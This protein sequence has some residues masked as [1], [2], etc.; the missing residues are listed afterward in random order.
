MDALCMFV[1]YPEDAKVKTRLAKDI[2][3]KEAT[4][5]YKRLLRILIPEHENRSYKFYIAVTPEGKVRKFKKLYP[6]GT[7]IKQKGDNLGEIITH[8]LQRLHGEH[9][10]VIL[11]GSDC[12]D[13]THETITQA[14][15]ALD[16]N[17]VVIGPAMDGGYYLIG[18]NKYHNLFSE[19]DWSSEKVLDQ[20]LKLATDLKV[21]LL[22]EKRD[23]DTVDDA[24]HH[25]F[26]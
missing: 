25:H 15:N 10:K 7:M 19:I 14:L 6:T 22:D 26:L 20:T 2:G 4:A 17:D 18:M 24:K 11:I 9:K 1:K 5:I 21:K 8:A 12:P 13:V 16:E 23:I 3:D